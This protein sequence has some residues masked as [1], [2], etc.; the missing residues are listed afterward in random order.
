MQSVNQEVFVDMTS[1]QTPAKM[2][3]TEILLQLKNSIDTMSTGMDTFEN[4]LTT[5]ID[6]LENNYNELNSRIEVMS[7]KATSAN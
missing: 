1:K 3:K 5:K 4:T 7:N 6:A 2:S